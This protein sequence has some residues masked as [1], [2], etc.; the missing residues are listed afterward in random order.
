MIDR[1]DAV[2]YWT[3]EVERQFTYHA[4]TS[5]QVTKYNDLRQAAKELALKIALLC[6]DSS[7]KGNALDKLREAVMWANASIACEEE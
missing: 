3:S 7:E 4:P 6:P 2:A 5:E 1:S